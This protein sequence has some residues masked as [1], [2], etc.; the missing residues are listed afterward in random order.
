MAKQGLTAKTALNLVK[1]DRT[2][3][4]CVGSGISYP[5]FPLW[6]GL[7]KK[8]VHKYVPAADSSFADLSKKLSSEVFLQAAAEIASKNHEEFS[9]ELAEILYEGLFDGLLLNDKEIVKR[10][11][12]N[13]PGS[14]EIEWN[15]FL[16]IVHR[17]SPNKTTAETL[18]ETILKLR[19]QNHAPAS[20]LTFN[21]E[22]L[23]GSL[24]NAIAHEQYAERKKFFDYMI[25]P[26]SYHEK[27]RIPY[28]FCHGVMPVPGTW[29]KGRS[30]FN[31][32]DRLVFLEN[33]YLQ[34]AN[35]SYSW[36]SSTFINTLTNHTVFF[37]GL[38]FVDPNIRRWLAWIQKERQTA[39][40]KKKPITKKSPNGVVSTS[41]Y[42]IEKKP[43][44]TIQMRMMEASV[45]HLGIRIIWIDDWEEVGIVLENGIVI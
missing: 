13:D 26:T 17:K 42:W 41:H 21:A 22:M 23:L 18:A 10:C 39:L 35:S 11:L 5:I 43:A 7:A 44:S 28:Y 31:A 20:I 37:V 6:D 16:N 32:D 45:S 36:Q 15:E 2:W 12:T 8:I 33:E 27:N 25:E 40:L 3:A 34:L 24:M 9:K 14:G 29:N 4:L 19:A 1:R 38:S 30:M